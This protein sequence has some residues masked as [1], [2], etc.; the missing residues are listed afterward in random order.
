MNL[1]ILSHFIQVQG[2]QGDYLTKYGYF[3]MQ[4]GFITIN[5]L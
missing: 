4:E 1:M 5:L 3:S 2:I